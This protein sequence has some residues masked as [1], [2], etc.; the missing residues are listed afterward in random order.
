MCAVHWEIFSAAGWPTIPGTG[1]YLKGDLF[2]TWKKKK[3][4]PSVGRCVASGQAETISLTVW[5]CRWKKKKRKENKQMDE[6]REE[7]EWTERKRRREIHADDTLCVCCVCIRA[8]FTQ[9]KS[10]RRDATSIVLVYFYIERQVY[11]YSLLVWPLLLAV[12]RV[13]ANLCPHLSTLGRMLLLLGPNNL[14]NLYPHS[15]RVLYSA[16]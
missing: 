8:L 5:S 3:T 12:K 16:D 6:K 2:R 11:I 9:G 7:R 14:S 13:P 1:N 4:A 15:R 10:F